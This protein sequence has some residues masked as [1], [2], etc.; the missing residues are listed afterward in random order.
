M[1]CY[2][3][4]AIL[5]TI[6]G[7]VLCPNH[8]RAAPSFNCGGVL[9]GTEQLVC[10]NDVLSSA[11][12]ML[13][14]TYR[15]VLELTTTLPINKPQLQ[16]EQREWLKSRS[17]LCSVPPDAEPGDEIGK[18]NAMV[19]LWDLYRRRT[20]EL[21]ALTLAAAPSY[22]SS[23][24]EITDAAHLD[25]I[26]NH[27]QHDD[28]DRFFR[29][30]GPR[31]ESCDGA[32]E[33]VVEG[34]GRDSSYGAHCRINVHETSVHVLMCDPGSIRRDHLPAGRLSAQTR[35]PAHPKGIE[36][37][38]DAVSIPLASPLPLGYSIHSTASSD[39]SGPAHP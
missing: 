24:I 38:A 1:H 25:K 28:L 15:H 23:T 13:S 27:F 8:G 31:I 17:R 26:R 35:H 11:D 34:M 14:A 32:I 19:C 10:A 2:R 21:S 33:L 39:T 36:R 29:K 5:L 30:S 12:V 22:R 9:S 16:Q 20:A 7:F 6:L 18:F 4:S 3:N 37:L